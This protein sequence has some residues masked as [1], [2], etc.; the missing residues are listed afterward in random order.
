M[1]DLELPFRL[2]NCWK[3]IPHTAMKTNRLILIPILLPSVLILASCQDQAEKMGKGFRLPAGSEEKGKTAFV[4]MGCN[5][6]HTVAGV[7]L[8]KPAAPSAVAFELGGAV[9]QVKSYGELVTSIIQPQHVVSQDYLEKLKK[10]QRE[11]AKSPM[12]DFNERL[13]VTQLTDIVTF[14]HSTYQKAPPPGANYP[15]YMP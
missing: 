11:G 12:P 7:E 4:A 9:R 1:G 2:E 13:T 8:A 3:G 14:L 6:C 5:Q 10:E 15:V